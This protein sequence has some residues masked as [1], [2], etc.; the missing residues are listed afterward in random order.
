MDNPYAVRCILMGDHGV[1][2][3]TLAQVFATGKFNPDIISTI[4]VSFVAKDLTIP[5]SDQMVK[6]QL[7]DTAGTERFK[8][9]IRSYLRDAYIVII[10][11]DIT[12]RQSWNNIENW[13]NDVIKEKRY[14]SIPQFVL[15]GTKSD[16]RDHAV[17]HQE[18]KARAKE[19]GCDHYVIS[20]K[21][22]NSYSMI[23]RIFVKAA[24][25]VHQTF[26][27]NIENGVGVPS[28]ILKP[29]EPPIDLTSGC[30][31]I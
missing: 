21:Q 4:G 31:F 25:K 26:K 1:G 18:I 29:K 19:W 24:E 3:S 2:K 22:K 16:L 7:W 20:S 12:N 23:H 8:S 27:T 10:Y 13:H 14:E 6:F 11:F 9:I 30:C 17:T 5:N 28:M 15:V